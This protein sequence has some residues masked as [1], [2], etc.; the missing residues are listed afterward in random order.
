VNKLR[1]TVVR[2][3]RTMS[4]AAREAISDAQKL[5]RAKQKAAAKK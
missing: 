2:K 3:R 5:R 4:A 1:G